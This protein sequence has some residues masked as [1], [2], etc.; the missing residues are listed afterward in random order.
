VNE[1]AVEAE[2]LV[3]DYGKIRALDGGSFKIR[4]GGIF[5]FL[6]PN[7]AGK[8]TTVEILQCLQA[9]NQR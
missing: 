3:M 4:R 1:Y 6:G 2:E 8:T 7:E 9:F 5:A